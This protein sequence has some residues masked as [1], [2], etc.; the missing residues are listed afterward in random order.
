MIDKKRQ[1]EVKDLLMNYVREYRLSGEE[2]YTCLLSKIESYHLD[3][4]SFDSSSNSLLYWHAVIDYVEEGLPINLLHENM[5]SFCNVNMKDAY[6]A[7]LSE[8]NVKFIRDLYDSSDRVAILASHYFIRM[9]K[10]KR[11]HNAE[12]VAFTKSM[13]MADPSNWAIDI[14]RDYF[15]LEYRLK[16]VGFGGWEYFSKKFI[17]FLSFNLLCKEA[18][19]YDDYLWEKFYNRNGEKVALKI[20][21]TK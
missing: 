18:R 7:G 5:Q 14:L 1:D 20:L 6:R 8:E 11:K 17:N 9:C 10:V 4:S 13:L 21:E 16:L 19:D 2:G 15:R 12:L 3:L